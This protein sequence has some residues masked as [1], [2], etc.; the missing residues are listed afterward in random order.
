VVGHIFPYTYIV[1]SV[2]FLK[3][4]E[5]YKQ[6]NTMHQLFVKQTKTVILDFNKIF[7]HRAVQILPTTQRS[8]QCFARMFT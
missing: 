4:L 5:S 2:E 8:A 1:H 6:S 7:T 3:L